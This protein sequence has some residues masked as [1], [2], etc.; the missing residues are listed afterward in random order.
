MSILFTVFV[1]ILIINAFNLIDGIDGLAGS[2]A[3][4]ASLIFGVLFYQ[5]GNVNVA[6]LAFALIGALIPFLKRNFSRHNKIFMGDT[7]SMIIGFLLAL[8]V[9]SFLSN[10]YFLEDAY[11]KK[12]APVIAIA[13]LFFPLMDTLR[14]FIIR[15]F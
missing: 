11:Y 10:S 8:F 2:I 7:G 1:F 5:T 14:I 13:I 3:L 6:T 15:I 12:S 4:F 9:V